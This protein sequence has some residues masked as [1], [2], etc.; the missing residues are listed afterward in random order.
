MKKVIYYK[1]MVLLAFIC[2]LIAF[3]YPKLWDELFLG[4][5]A[6]SIIALMIYGDKK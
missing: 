4:G 1:L 2:Y 5:I 6:F 3:I